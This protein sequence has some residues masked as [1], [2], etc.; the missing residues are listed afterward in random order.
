M[1]ARILLALREPELRDALRDRFEAE[2]FATEVVADGDAAVELAR[3]GR[4][5]CAVLE[6]GLPGRSGLDALRALRAELV[7]LPVVLLTEPD[8]LAERVARPMN[9]ADDH[10]AMPFETDEL[11]ARVAAVLRRTAARAA[12]D[13]SP[14]VA[15]AEEARGA[16]RTVECFDLVI[17]P[18]LRRV[19]RGAST[20][21][22]GRI[23]LELLLILASTPGRIWTREQLGDVLFGEAWDPADGT[24]EDRVRQLR[25]ALGSRPDGSPYV[26]PAGG[27]GFRVARPDEDP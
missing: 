6:A 25:E 2:G 23:E 27:T 14:I 12:P 9:G 19:Q 21:E 22:L 13:L 5:E 10:L 11:L 3:R 24:L 18:A 4:Y 16:A 1:A 7:D 17:T 15:P 8:D 20:I 26:E